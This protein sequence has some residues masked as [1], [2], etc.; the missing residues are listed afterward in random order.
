MRTGGGG[1]EKFSPRKNFQ[2]CNIIAYNL[3]N[4]A[5]E[6]LD[7]ATSIYYITSCTF[8]DHAGK[9]KT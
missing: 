9:M 8:H 6:N 7:T 3:E 1:K 2:L 4:S 5:Y